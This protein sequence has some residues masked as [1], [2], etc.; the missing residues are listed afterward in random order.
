MFE[1][2]GEEGVSGIN[3]G[4]IGEEVGHHLG[5]SEEDLDGLGSGEL[6]GE[7]VKLR[8]EMLHAAKELRFEDAAR[9]RDRVR[10]LEGLELQR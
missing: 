2:H 4:P 3:L 9:V 10:Q 8:E 1:V 5:L 7:I 6:R